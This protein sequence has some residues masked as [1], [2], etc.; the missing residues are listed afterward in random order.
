MTSH[1]ADTPVLSQRDGEVLRLTLNRPERGNS[2][3]LPLLDALITALNDHADAQA[4]I[5]TG[6]GRAFSTGGDIGGFLDHAETTDTLTDYASQLV[7]RLNQT[8][9]ALADHQGFI[10]SDVNGP[11]TGG[12]IGLMLIADHVLLDQSAFI[13][14]YYAQMGFAP[15]GGW[16]AILPDQ[17]G[18]HRA[19]NWLTRDLRWTADMAGDA[20]LADTM[21]DSAGRTAQIDSLL[22][23]A[24]QL[25]GSVMAQARRLTI[26]VDL[27]DRL[28]AE[29][30]AFLEQI[31]KPETLARM[32]AFASPSKT[33]RKGAA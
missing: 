18:R 3:V 23:H 1:G 22:Q 8:L 21:A 14:P 24:A 11:V 25:D 28:E 33:S 19:L 13:Q 32:Q 9:L 30:Q 4:L 17:I 15:D 12:S 31:R 29:R 16:T 6:A 5:L 10:I 27:A 7:G 26:G 2:L 20:G